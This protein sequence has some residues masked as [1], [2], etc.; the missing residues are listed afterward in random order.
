VEGGKAH[1]K[2]F[3]V[4]RSDARIR[5]R[6]LFPTEQARLLQ[7]DTRVVDLQLRRKDAVARRKARSRESFHG[8]KVRFFREGE[9][10][11]WTYLRSAG[12]R[13]EEPLGAQTGL[14]LTAAV[15]FVGASLR[16]PDPQSRWI[17]D[18]AS[19]MATL[20]PLTV[21]RV[22][23]LRGQQ[24]HSRDTGYLPTVGF[25]CDAHDE[26]SNRNVR[27]NGTIRTAAQ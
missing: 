22:A 24:A 4:H 5:H 16:A 10:W 20:I 9:G 25:R 14:R 2:A 11:R 12:S 17:M 1:S 27:W 3:D 19:A 8:A 18:N 13:N 15:P 23:D 6:G 26:R 21:P 7:G